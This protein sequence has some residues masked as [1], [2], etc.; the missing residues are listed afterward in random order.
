[1]DYQLDFKI[2]YQYETT[3]LGITIPVVL[4]VGD[5]TADANSKFDPGS[6][7]C[8]FQREIADRLNLD[9]ESGFPQRMS[10]IGWTF[11]AYGHHLTLQFLGL[12]IESMVF[13]AAHYGLPRNL[14]GRIGCMDRMLIGLDVYQELLYLNPTMG[15]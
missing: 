15:N 9:V 12:T 5:L 1:M 13:F 2:R 6:E 7:F 11:D 10:S 14:L 8:L 3:K 4:S